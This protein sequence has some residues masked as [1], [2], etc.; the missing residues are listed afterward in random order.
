M[1]DLTV[2]NTLLALQSFDLKSLKAQEVSL[3]LLLLK[4]AQRESLR[5]TKLATI[6]DQLEDA[7][8]DPHIVEH[9]TPNEQ[10]QRYEL[11]TR[12]TQSASTYIA[13]AVKSVNWTDIETKLMI[14]SQETMSDNSN[15]SGVNIDL[16][17]AAL[18][19]L[20]QLSIN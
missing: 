2:P 12:A 15:T 10:I 20:K 19:L 5:I 11:A 16:Q 1:N 6:I 8:F 3:N 7:I 18:S 14:L 17:Q 9:L 13:Q 4:L